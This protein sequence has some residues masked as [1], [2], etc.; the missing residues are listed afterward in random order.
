VT[1]SWS[2]RLRDGA[3]LLRLS[4][5]M[6]AGRRAWLWPLVT[7]LWPAFQIFRV[8]IRWRPTEYGPGDAQVVLIGFP[9]T[10]LGIG[11]GMRII[12]GELDRRTLEIAYTV[13][14]GTH[15][16]WLSKI[17][18]SIA[19]LLGAEALLALATFF[20]CTEFPPGALYGALQGAVFYL[21]LSMGLSA[22][23]KSEAAGALLTSLVLGLNLFFQPTRVSP[24]FNPE[25]HT[26]LDPADILA[27]TVQNRIGMVLA[28]VAITLLAFGRAENREKMLGG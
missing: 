14:G 2:G 15:R 4:L 28:V 6:V 12:A 10:V 7:L 24:S 16:I 26:N 5:K 19:L 27:L 23:C 13:P 3:R 1:G 25:T 9:L 8:L 21:A 17:A 22:L 20:F 18:A 11:L